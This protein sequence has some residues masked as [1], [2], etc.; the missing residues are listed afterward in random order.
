[1]T[2]PESKGPKPKKRRRDGP[3]PALQSLTLHPDTVRSGATEQ[4]LVEI[5]LD[6]PAPPGGVN[7]QVD[8]FR[9]GADGLPE[10]AQAMGTALPIFV[11]EGETTGSLAVPA[12]FRFAPPG[13]VE[14]FRFEARLGDVSRTAV[15]HIVG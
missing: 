15:F 10:S 7:V 2:T 5:G 1:M 9:I 11:G 13:I 6:G 4:L 8:V 12:S 3:G 14:D